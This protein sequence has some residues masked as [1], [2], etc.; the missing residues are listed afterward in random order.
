M[1]GTVNLLT[2]PN[3]FAHSRDTIAICVCTCRRPVML[4]HCLDSLAAQ[5]VPSDVLPTVIVVENDAEPRCRGIVD[6]FAASC[7]YP[8]VYV[9]EPVR[10]IARARNAA[11]D[12]ARATGSEWIAFIDDDETAAP[13]WLAGLMAPEYR[14]V[15]VLQGFHDLVYPAQAPFWSLEKDKK[16]RE[17]DEGAARKVAV[18]NNVRFSAALVHAGLRF[19][20][21]I[22]LMGGEDIDFFGRA[23]LAGFDI[24]FTNR[25]VTR[26][27]VH[28][29]RLTYRAQVYR[30]YWC[31]ASDVRM[32][33][34]TRGTMWAW[35]RKAHTVP[36]QMFCGAVELL[37][38]PLFAVA[39][40]RHFKR[41]AVA[42]GKKI[43]KAAGRAVAMLGIMPKPYQS[44]VGR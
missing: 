5:V 40:V 16:V 41:R 21:R 27:T 18:T 3:V 19:D 15:P 17:R 10:G 35:T 31:A 6:A 43:G 1:I 22:G 34:A 11:L 9:H 7:T 25:A 32:W 29:E 37:A 8:V 39:G 26:E 30:S 14:H 23:H 44:V 33:K 42:G 2:K 24:R 20:E 4:R 38:A 13:G 28:P 36:T 12:A